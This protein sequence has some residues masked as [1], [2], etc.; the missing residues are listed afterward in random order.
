[1]VA[2]C[3][4]LVRAH[5][6]TKYQ[7]VPTTP[8]PTKTK[9]HLPTTPPPHL[10]TSLPP[11]HTPSISGIECQI[12]MTFVH[13]MFPPGTIVPYPYDWYWIEKSKVRA[14]VGVRTESTL[15]RLDL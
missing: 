15:R 4:G 11:Y 14:W 13:Q 1:M 10:A 2:Y 9:A 6:G 12:A 8:P 7:E 5:L 3:L